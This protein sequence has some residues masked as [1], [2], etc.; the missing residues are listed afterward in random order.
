MS[1]DVLLVISLEHQGRGTW[2][3]CLHLG[4]IRAF[5]VYSRRLINSRG[6]N[7]KCVPWT[8]FEEMS[9]ASKGLSGLAVCSSSNSGETDVLIR[10]LEKNSFQWVYCTE[11]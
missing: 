10:F 11:L 3:D 8:D 6:L 5:G 1:H 7:D 4:G 9:N 2:C